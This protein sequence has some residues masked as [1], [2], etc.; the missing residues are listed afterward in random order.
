MKK[1]RTEGY[2]TDIAKEVSWLMKTARTEG[3]ETDT[4]IPKNT[5]E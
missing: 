2:E 5:E 4:A 3:Y 1:A